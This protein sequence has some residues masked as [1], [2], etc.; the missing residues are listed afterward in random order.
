MPITFTVAERVA[1]A[2]VF[3]TDPIPGRP[4]RAT[5]RKE[6]SPEE[7]LTE[8]WDGGSCKGMF[9]DVEF[10]CEPTHFIFQ[11]FLQTSLKPGPDFIPNESGFVHGVI[12][13]YNDHHNLIIRYTSRPQNR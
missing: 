12:R 10:G 2:N 8:I 7:V 6:W 1:P 3:Q 5:L 13:A 11:E 4:T 9:L